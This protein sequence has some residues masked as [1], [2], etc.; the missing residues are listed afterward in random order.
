MKAF[1]TI[2]FGQLISNLGSGLTA[3]ALGVYIY[4]RTGSVTELSLAV[5]AASLPGILLSPIAGVV[6]DRWDRRWVLI[7]SDTGAALSTLAIWLLLG[8]GKLEIWHIYVA[9]VINASLGAFQSPA[10]L[11]SITMLVPKQHLGR[12]AGLGQVSDALSMIAT[13]ILAG[14]LVVAIQLEGVILIDFATFLFAILTLLLVRVPMPKAS[15]EGQAGRGSFW[16]EA[17]YGWKYLK[18]RSGLLGLLILLA[19]INFA[20]GFHSVLFTPLVLSF[21]DADVLGGILSAGGLG[22][23]AGS[24]IMSTWGGTR[25]KIIS[26]LGALFTFGIA[27]SLAGLR[28]DPYLIG[29][30]SFVFLLLLPIARGSSQAIW[31]VKVPPDIQGRVFAIRGLIASIIRPLALVAAGPLADRVFEPLMAENG[32]WANSLGRITGSGVGRGIGL[33]FVV[34]GLFISLAT[35][36]GCLSP[37]IRNVERELP[38]AIEQP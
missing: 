21:A 12:A 3:F 33:L 1:L 14:F 11:A 7:L 6:V 36:I 37:R 17:G 9:N 35:V 16:P 4:Q 18:V 24:L 32:A 34:M 26:L 13:P 2:W 22:M 25:R 20:L 30:A 19:F 38:D 15:A 28:A 27:I 29:A 8:S 31:Q 5:L 23:L 10:Y